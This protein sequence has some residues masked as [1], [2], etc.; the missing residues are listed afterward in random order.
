MDTDVA[1][2]NP[3]LSGPYEPVADERDDVGLEV[4]GTLPPQ[5]RGTYVRNGPNPALAPKGRY[6][7]FDG[8]GMVHAVQI[9][10][11][12]A[13]YRNRW[14]RSA[15]LEA[16]LRAGE[17]L[18]GGL[19]EF[20]LPPA[21]V[22]AEVGVMKNTANTNVLAHA[23]RLFALMEAA[24]P[25]ELDGRLAT[26]GEVDFGGRLHGAMT[27]H[28]KVDPASGE[29]VSFGYSPVPPYLRY[30]VVD[31]SGALTTEVDIDLPG[32]VMMHDF[33]VS[34]TRAV[35]FDLPAL[36][37][38]EAMLSG[39][40]GIRWDPSHGARIGVLDRAA[41]HDGVTWIEV[42]PFFVFHFLNAHDDGDAVVVEG[43]RSERM[44]VTFGE[45][46]VLEPV[47]PS[48]H[49]WRIDPVAGTVTETRLDDRLSDFPRHDDA[50]AGRPLRYGY[51]GSMRP[52]GRERIDFSGLVK[53]DLVDGTSV[54][55]SWA[56]GGMG[57]EAVFVADEERD[58]EDG[59]WLLDFV[60][61]RSGSTELV[62]LDAEAM[63]EVARVRMPRRIP[64]GFHGNW[65]PEAAWPA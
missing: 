58:A 65:V 3:Y 25:V 13:S 31:A 39:R 17:A 5:L 12:A 2:P 30:H 11:G 41:P 44:N 26:L 23:G 43:C 62:V 29:L 10:D 50:R 6:H 49:R 56:D 37:D 53:H 48:L 64:F 45:D 46:H 18:F 52:V 36:F 21:E 7:V 47:Y 1:T 60:T 32:P 57:G 16:E 27:A 63:E 51:V 38:L 34:A 40:P 54:E 59:G 19:S 14:V 20:R 33:A 22:V 55:H 15:G 61:D 35:F 28:P 42:E 9:R 4:V 8:D 24:K